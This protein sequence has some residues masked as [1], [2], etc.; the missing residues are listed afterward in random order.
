M[1]LVLGHG[2]SPSVPPHHDE[3]LALAKGL[4]ELNAIERLW[5]NLK[6]RFLSHRLRP[7]ADAIVDAVRK[8]WQRLTSD[9]GRIGSL[10]SMEWA[11]AVRN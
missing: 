6:E 10:C 2:R 8:A 4:V 7:D 3:V 9:T 1:D 5:L 11:Q